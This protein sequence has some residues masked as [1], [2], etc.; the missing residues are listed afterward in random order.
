MASGELN[1][2]QLLVC[3]LIFYIL[4]NHGDQM[5]SKYQ[6]LHICK[7]NSYSMLFKVLGIISY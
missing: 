2:A 7:W 4:E 1:I 6:P 3:S 5:Q